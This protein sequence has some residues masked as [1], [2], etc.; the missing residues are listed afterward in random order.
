MAV[1]WVPG[2]DSQDFQKTDGETLEE[3]DRRKW[4]KDNDTPYLTKPLGTLDEL[5]DVKCLA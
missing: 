1:H 2:K 5:L 3:D 4:M